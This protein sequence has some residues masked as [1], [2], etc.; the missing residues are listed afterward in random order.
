MMC[1]RPRTAPVDVY[2]MV[3]NSCLPAAPPVA[4]PFKP[5]SCSPHTLHTRQL[6]CTSHEG[7]HE[8]HELFRRQQ[9]EGAPHTRSHLP[10]AFPTPVH[11]CKLSC[12]SHEGH[13]EGH[14]FLGGQ[15]REGVARCGGAG[16]AEGAWAVG[17]A[18]H[19]ATIT[20]WSQVWRGEEGGSGQETTEGWETGFHISTTHRYSM[21]D[22]APPHSPSIAP[23]PPAHQSTGGASPT[24][25]AGQAGG[26]RRAHEQAGGRTW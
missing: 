6:S 19:A 22:P 3:H 17:C 1:R 26:P 12:T 7:H 20:A 13:H 5:A 25:W 18:A 8:G 2:G 11:T 21:P 16:G 24:C 23:S 10:A 15:Q 14:E 9:R 4:H